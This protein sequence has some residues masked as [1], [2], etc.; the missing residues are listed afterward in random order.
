LQTVGATGGSGRLSLG[1]GLIRYNS[2]RGVERT[3]KYKQTET[4]TDL[5]S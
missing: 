4:A 3:P 5:V 1:L 2:E